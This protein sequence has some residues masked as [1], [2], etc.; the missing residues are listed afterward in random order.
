MTIRK[1]L[2][3]C[4]AA[5]ALFTAGVVVGQNR[6][7]KPTSILHVVT[8]KWKDG[9]TPA[10][11][12]S[13]FAAVE[14]MAGQVDGIRNIWTKGI[15]VQGEG[16]TDA[17]VLE[18]RDRAAFDAYADNPAHKEFEKVYIPLRGRSTTHDITN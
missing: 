2:L 13:A 18:F 10:E 1:A 17:F 16:Y 3:A 15:K 8:I 12:Q 9:I 7:N 4:A 5:A 14:K 11:K 6:Y